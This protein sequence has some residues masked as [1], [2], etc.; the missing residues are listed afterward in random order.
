MLRLGRLQVA[1]FAASVKVKRAVRFYM[2]RFNYGLA[3]SEDAL[4]KTLDVVGLLS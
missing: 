1:G 3:N 4:G 2:K